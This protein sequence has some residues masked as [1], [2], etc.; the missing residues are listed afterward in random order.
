[1]IYTVYVQELVTGRERSYASFDT[2]A[3]A[4]ECKRI[5]ERWSNR[6]YIVEE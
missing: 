2:W 5:C 1:M 6:A 3:E 4:Y